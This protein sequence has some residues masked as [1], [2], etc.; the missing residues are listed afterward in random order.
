VERL[1]PEDDYFLRCEGDD[2]PLHI[3]ALLLFDESPNGLTPFGEAATQHLSARLPDTPLQRVRHEAPDEYD[4]DVWCDVGEVDLGQHVTIEHEPANRRD[5]LT[6]VESLSTERIDLARPPFHMHVF[7]EVEGGGHAAFLRT[8]HSVAD[9]IGFQNIIRL[10]TDPSPDQMPATTVRSFER[11]PDP[12]AWREESE[13]RF[14]QEAP[15][16]EAAKG[17]RAE[18]KQRL[19]DFSADPAHPKIRSPQLQRTTLSSP[20]RR[21]ETL[22]FS[23]SEVRAIGKALG[24]SVNDTFLTVVA[25]AVRTYFSNTGELPDEPLVAVG[26]R[27][28]RTPDDG[29]FGN[30]ILNLMTSLAT[31]IVDPRQRFAEISRASKVEIERSRLAEALIPDYDRPFGARNR[32]IQF[33]ESMQGGKRILPGNVVVSNVP[34][35]PEPRYFAGHRLRASYPAPILGYGRMLNVTLRRYVDDLHL[36]IMSDPVMLDDVEAIK[37]LLIDS[38]AELSHAVGLR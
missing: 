1:R 23:L 9:G 25:G 26:A 27:S 10:L 13:R 37:Q 36:G 6:R 4:A 2:A 3:G 35:P 32:R 28:Y 20:Q 8:H 22:D 16:F 19:A 11:P 33:E 17:Q 21:Y 24:G 15:L 34:G 29:P 31:D 18:A 7:S 14:K 38:L 12:R 5:L 30:R